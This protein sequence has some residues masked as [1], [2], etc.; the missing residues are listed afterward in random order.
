MKAL[1]R[2]SFAA[3]LMAGSTSASAI[4]QVVAPIMDIDGLVEDR[5]DGHDVSFKLGSAQGQII[6]TREVSTE[7]DTVVPFGGTTIAAAYNLHFSRKVSMLF[8]GQ[9]LLDL[10]NSQVVRQGISLG[11]AY[12]LFGGVR[13]QIETHRSVT[14]TR[15]NEFNL[16][17]IGRVT[18]QN[19]AASNRRATS[20][21]VSGSVFEFL[22]GGEFRYDLSEG[23][24]LG[25]EALVTTFT[26]PA[27]VTRL[28]P[29]A[30]EFAF[31][32]RFFI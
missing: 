12:H 19:Y 13:R 2:A 14:F 26:L 31:F 7:K 10:N 23:H 32:W 28:T 22:S 4:E 15:R 6:K 25:V 9:F 17:L 30:Q 8:Q 3:V 24:A 27:S 18:F 1:A 5:T 29:V 21:G 11:A 20:K 16:S